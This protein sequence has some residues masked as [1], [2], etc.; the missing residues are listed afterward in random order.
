MANS[1]EI[2]IQGART[3]NLKNVSLSIPH[4]QLVVVTGISGSGKSS[5]VFDILA[6][7][8]Q[9]RYFETLPSFS[10]QFTGKLNRPEVESIEGLSPVIAI[11]QSTAGM[12]ARSTVGTMSDIY[13]LLRLLFARTGTTDRP[14]ELSRALFSFNSEKGKCPHC[15]GIGKQEEIDLNKLIVHPEKTIREG[16]LAPTL[17]TGYIMYS[18]V[19]ID[20]LNQVCNAEGFNVDIPWNELTEAQQHVI[21]YGS[22]KIKVPFGKHSLESR[23][24]WTGIKAKPREEGYYKGMIPIMSDILRRDRNANILKYVH[25]ITCEECHGARL[26][27]DARSVKV[28]D[29]N[30]SELSEFELNQLHNW[31]SDNTW[32]EVATPIVQKIEAQIALLKDLGLGH[33]TVNRSAKSLSASE[34]Q[35]IRIANQIE[36]ALCDVLYVFDEP[37]IGLHP[38]ENKRMIHHFKELVRRGNTVIVVEHDLETI[39]QADHIID[40]GPGAGVEGGEVLFNGSLEDYQKEKAL[41]EVSPTYNAITEVVEP[42]RHKYAKAEG[43]I[44]LNS[45]HERNLKHIDVAIQQGQLN[46][47]SGRSGVGKTSLV[48]GTLMR[49]VEQQLGMPIDEPLKVHSTKNLEQLDKLVFI[50]HKP[51]GKTPRSNPA[52]YLGLSDHIRD[53]FASLPEAKE[54]KFSK[55]RFSFNNKGGRCETCQGAGK[56]QIGMHFLG[57]VDLVCGTCNGDRFNE[58]TLAVKYNGKSIADIYK[59]SVDRALEFFHD[60]QKLLTGLQLLHDI[61]LGYLTLGQSSTTLSGG[62]AQRIKITNQLQKKDTGN[63]LY[64]IIEP[65][66]GLH[67]ANIQSLLDL[68]DNIKAKGNTIVCIEQSEDIIAHSD[69]HIELGEEGGTNG[70]TIIHQ[71]H[72]KIVEATETDTIS[73]EPAE[74]INEIILKGVHTHNLKHIDVRIPKQ[75]LTVVTGLS[76]SGKSSLVYDS[77]FAEANARFT[78]SLS[79]YNRSFIEQNSEAKIE[80]Y[81]GLGPAIG[82]N[83]KGGSPS[84]RSTVG[85]LSGVYDALRLLYSRIAQHEG[86]PYTAQHFSFNSHL[87]ACEACKGLGEQ[88]ECDPDKVIVAPEQSIL[89]G[90]ASTNKVVKYYADPNGQFIATIKTIAQAQGWNPEVAWNDLSAEEQ[91]TILYG[92]GEQSWDVTWEFTT[93]S[94]TG[95][96]ELNTKWPGLCNL[97]DD[98]YRRKLHNK[99]ITYLEELL[100]AVECPTCNGSRLKDELLTVHFH[101]KNIHELSQ[102][103]IEACRD[104]LATPLKDETI[105]A[106]AKVV[107]PPVNA[108]LKRITEL[109][110]GYLTLDRSARTLSGGERQRI[111]LAGQFSAHLFGVIYVLDEPTIGL[112]A[113][114]V[115]VLTEILRTMVDNGNT[116]IVVEHDADFIR[117]ADYVVELGPGAGTHGGELIYQG[118]L[119]NVIPES[120][121]YQLLER[122]TSETTTKRTAKG[123]FGLKGAN[124][125]NLKDIDISFDLGC[126]TAVT[127]ISGSGKSSLIKDALYASWNRKRPVGCTSTFGLEQFE[128]ILL[129]DQEPLTQNRL[130]TPASYTGVLEQLRNYFAKS[131][132]AKELKLKKGDFS[133]QSKTGKCP[134]CNGHGKIKT[135]MDFMSDIWLPCHTCHGLRYNDLILDCKVN[136]HSIGDVLRMTVDEAL[137]FFSTD[138]PLQESLSLLQRVGV[139][140]LQLGQ[141]G[142]TLSGG[143]AQRLKL[144]TSLLHKRKGATLYLFDEP[145]TGLHYFDIVRLLD[146]FDEIVYNGDTVIFIEH[147]QTM[148]EHA[149]TCVTL[150]PGSGEHGGEIV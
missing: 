1:P 14:I 139:G 105:K 104:I 129:I 26:N 70:G 79:T 55:S 109:G 107:I 88:L 119:K 148:I 83:R 6:Q 117:S 75:A 69:W 58:E 30:I 94:R 24:K 77:L 21:L 90:A 51:I 36:V 59:L 63:T 80:S 11:G 118:S 81:T 82:I 103:S 141:A 54:K 110:L 150:G 132:E 25:A 108:S 72:P 61:G 133:Y 85:T 27:A 116:V 98:E 89:D 40:M 8:G 45:C 10:R 84:L 4:N 64:I 140:H 35:R 138:K 60:Q 32:K 143:E 78:E 17:P 101:G 115:K 95:T 146:V 23:L 134:T 39:R 144:A 46:V 122:K 50:D 124:A 57:N 97:I 37:S 2:V 20:V 149:D 102:L 131:A 22:E 123:T 74:P 127:G 13:D 128:D 71:G 52:T 135:S 28:H 137:E 120:V 5:L 19:T 99:N 76:G 62:E 16:A 92:T 38:E 142:N 29:K 125:N 41:A 113:A 18:Q 15:N 33:L 48:L 73:R 67:H 53:L 56:V 49:A 68:F 100:H 106:I 121:T 93:K 47:V 42:K 86:K 111:T 114:Q 91:Q 7:E 65:S 31:I 112:D 44:L 34:I 9:R 96:Q 3:H 126:M 87:G 130:M 136:D 43:T 145:S 147:N 12:Q 66:I